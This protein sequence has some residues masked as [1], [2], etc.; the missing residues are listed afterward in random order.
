MCDMWVCYSTVGTGQCEAIS[1]QILT[2]LPGE[3]LSLSSSMGV[4]CRC[5]HIEVLYVYMQYPYLILCA[6]FFDFSYHFSA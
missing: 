5:T 4:S 1:V 2:L 6:F 3:L